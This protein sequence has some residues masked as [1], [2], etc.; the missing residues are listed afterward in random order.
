MVTFS[1]IPMSNF[2][3]T[4]KPLKTFIFEKRAVFRT[5]RFH[6]VTIQIWLVLGPKTLNATIRV[7]LRGNDLFWNR[8]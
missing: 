2:I 3:L 5:R 4:Q 1:Q 7:F 8:V 6:R